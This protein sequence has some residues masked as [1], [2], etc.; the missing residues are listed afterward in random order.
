MKKLVIAIDGPAAS[1]K[2]T[3][4]KLAARRL[5]YLFVDTG[6]MY[7]AMTLKVLEHDIDLL[8]VDGITALAKQT[9]IRL[10]QTAGELTVFLDDRNVSELIRRQNVTRAVSAISAV[11]G[12]R[13]LMV[14]EQRK[15]GEQG[16]IILEG[17]DIGTVVFPEADLKFY[18]VAEVQKR[19]MRRQKELN[20]QGVDVA[21][22]DLEREIDERDQKD[23][24][25]DISPLR[26]ADDALLIDTSEMKIEDQVEFIIQKAHELAGESS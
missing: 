22:E 1:G 7:R 25:R 8:D 26:R 15:M 21:I 13:E 17:R 23:S 12:V 2:S 18:M 4:S 10:Q 14:R 5:G 16:G 24:K 9:T 3:T 19:A 6:A 11:R 20:L